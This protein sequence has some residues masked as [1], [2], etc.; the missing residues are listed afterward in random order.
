MGEHPGVKELTFTD[1]DHL[2]GGPP[3]SFQL[4]GSDYV[5]LERA[6]AE[7]EAGL[8]EESD[9]ESLSSGDAAASASTE[10]TTKLMPLAVS[11]AMA[12]RWAAG[13][14]AGL[15]DDLVPFGD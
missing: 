1:A 12:P 14:L 2:G 3:L 6:A 5:A 13:H 9:D 4:S 7:L 11:H 15:I 10:R 8:R